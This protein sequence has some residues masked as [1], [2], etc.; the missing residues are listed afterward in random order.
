MMAAGV[1]RAVCVLLLACLL[2]PERLTQL[3]SEPVVTEVVF[4]LLLEHKALHLHS[5]A[6]Q[7]VAVAGVAL[8]VVA[9]AQAP[10]VQVVAQVII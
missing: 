2:L 9:L 4:L 3:L 5:M 6:F 1:V 8:E 7:P 10:E